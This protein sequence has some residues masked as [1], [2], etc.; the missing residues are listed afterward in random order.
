MPLFSKNEEVLKNL[1]DFFF[2]EQFM[3]HSKTELKIEISHM[4]PALCTAT[5]TINT[6]LQPE[7]LVHLL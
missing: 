5:P 1:M 3:V 6:P 4:P 7:W 2:L